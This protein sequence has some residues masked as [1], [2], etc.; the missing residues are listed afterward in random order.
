MGDRIGEGDFATVW[1]ATPFRQDK[2]GSSSTFLERKRGTHNVL[3]VMH[4]TP[5]KFCASRQVR[6]RWRD[7]C[8]SEVCLYS[9][10]FHRHAPR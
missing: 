2:C 4:Q 3:S 8:L 9:C 10:C 6:P 7:Q 1:I 5:P